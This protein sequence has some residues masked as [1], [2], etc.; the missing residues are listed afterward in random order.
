MRPPSLPAVLVSCA[1]LYRAVKLVWRVSGSLAL[2]AI[3]AALVSVSLAV[4]ERP[5]TCIYIH[6]TT[7]ILTVT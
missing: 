3:S 4:L 7:V 1:V 5:Y 2:D 6:T